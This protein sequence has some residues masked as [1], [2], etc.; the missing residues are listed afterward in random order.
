MP[1]PEQEAVMVKLEPELAEGV[2]VQPEA[3]P[4]CSKSSEVR[5]EIATFALKARLNET[6][7]LVGEAEVEPKDVTDGGRL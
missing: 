4:I 3:E 1:E 2:K 7:P 6:V 5:P